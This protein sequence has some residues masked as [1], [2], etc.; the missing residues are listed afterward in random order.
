MLTAC[1]A[2]MV[3]C[4]RRD[5]RRRTEGIRFLPV[6]GGV[7]IWSMLGGWKGEVMGRQQEEW[8]ECNLQLQASP[9]AP[10]IADSTVLAKTVILLL[11]L[12]AL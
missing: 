6:A 7:Q 5:I 2:R 4:I 3:R 12:Q 11:G 10:R 8:G 1:G 9:L